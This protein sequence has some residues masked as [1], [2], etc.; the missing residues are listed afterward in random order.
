[1]SHRLGVAM[2][3]NVVKLDNGHDP[4][5]ID[6]VFRAINQQASVPTLIIAQTIKGRGLIGAENNFCGYHTISYCPVDRVDE[7]TARLQAEISQS[8]VTRDE[9]RAHIRAAVQP[10]TNIPVSTESAKNPTSFT[11]VDVTPALGMNFHHACAH[12]YKQLSAQIDQPER[13]DYYFLT[14]DLFPVDMA[15]ECG[16]LNIRN[17]LDVGLREQHM[18]AMAHG[19]SVTDPQARIHI[20]AAEAFTFRALDQM[21]AA[22]QGESRMVILAD[23][24]GLA[25][26]RNGATHQSAVQ[27]FGVNWLPNTTL[28]EPSDVE[29]YFTCLNYTLAQNDRIYYIRA[30]SLAPDL[31]PKQGFSQAEPRPFYEVGGPV[32]GADVT[33]VGSGITTHYL[34]KAQSHLAGQG[35]RAKVLNVT[36]PSALGADFVA[37][38]TP[39]RP[40]LCFYNGH[41]DF[42]PSVISPKILAQSGSQKPSL[43]KG[44]GFELGDSGT[45][46]ELIGKYGLDDAGVVRTIRAVLAGPA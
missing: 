3:G 4:L 25:N 12:Y 17:Y 38:I 39:G 46:P 21:N 43:L 5:A 26:S 41:G 24:A 28:L 1:M 7:L 40:C 35:V 37:A 34:Y 13:P 29:D 33:L 36:I 27:P 30:H 20:S 8:G 45:T 9:L 31:L 15:K 23:K 42:L 22:G 10:V 2:A 11:P 18:Y 44:Y 14:A 32:D 6:A 19:I 16:L